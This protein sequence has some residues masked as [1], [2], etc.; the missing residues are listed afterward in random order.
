MTSHSNGRPEVGEQRRRRKKS[1]SGPARQAYRS[2]GRDLWAA[3]GPY[4]PSSGRQPSAN[5]DQRRP[6]RAPLYAQFRRREPRTEQGRDGRVD[7]YAGFCALPCGRRRPSISTCRRRQ[8]QAAY[9][10]ASDGPSSSACAG[11]HLAAAALLALLRV[12]FTEPSRSPGMLV[13]SYPAVSP[14][15]RPDQG[16]ARRSVFCGTVPRVTPGCR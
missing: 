15:P 16:R 9:P 8:V 11:S 14:L 7:L 2:G 6:T 3:A 1:P 13:G 5:D 4:G 10:Q 12:G